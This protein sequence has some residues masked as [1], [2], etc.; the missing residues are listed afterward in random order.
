MRLKGIRATLSNL[1]RSKSFSVY[2]KQK[3]FQAYELVTS[4]L[5]AWDKDFIKRRS[6]EEAKLIAKESY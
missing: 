4:V 1:N 2:D 3:L 6:D 5:V